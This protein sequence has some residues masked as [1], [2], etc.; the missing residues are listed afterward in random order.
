M[1]EGVVRERVQAK[2][3]YHH[4]VQSGQTAG[5]VATAR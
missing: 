4:A 2:Q 5:H 3:E 1:M